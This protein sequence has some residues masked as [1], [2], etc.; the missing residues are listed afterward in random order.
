MRSRPSNIVSARDIIRA[1]EERD[2]DTL[3]RLTDPDVEWRSAFAVADGGLYRGHEGVQRYVAD[4]NDAWEV[5]RLAIEQELTIGDVVVFVGHIQ[6]EGKGSGAATES[7]AA[8]VLRF[9][10]G[11][12]THF[13]PVRDPERAF[14]ALGGIE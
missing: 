7:L 8:Y 3:I 5:V 10:E 11:R 4:M 6:V 12:L 13:R 2:V 9:R 14:A 1:V